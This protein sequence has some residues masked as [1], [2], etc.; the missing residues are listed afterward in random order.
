MFERVMF[1][2]VM[3][4]RVVFVCVTLVISRGRGGRHQSAS[5]ECINT[6]RGRLLLTSAYVRHRQRADAGKGLQ[7]H[8]GGFKE[9]TAI[10][11]E[12]SMPWLKKRTARR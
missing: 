11:A 8:Y 4:V 2:R 5:H 6:Y 10:S 9:G 7:S 3:F 12:F 1:E